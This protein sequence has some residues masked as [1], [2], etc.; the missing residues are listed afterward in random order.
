[1]F[2]IVRDVPVLQAPE[3][4]ALQQAQSWPVEMPTLDA[5][6]LPRMLSHAVDDAQKVLLRWVA[7]RMGI[8]YSRDLW[9]IIRK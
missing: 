8:A 2:F 6:T 7:L 3:F 5:Q 4:L 9:R 1:M